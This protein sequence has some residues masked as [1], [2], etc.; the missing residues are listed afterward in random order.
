M[1]C[2]IFSAVF[3]MNAIYPEIKLDGW[4]KV[5]L[6]DDKSKV[7]AHESWN[8]RI[9]PKMHESDRKSNRYY[10]WSSHLVFEE[11][12]Y[13][14]YFDSKFPI[15]VDLNIIVGEC[16]KRL[17]SEDK[18]AL[19]FKHPFRTC[20]YEELVAIHQRRMDTPQNI[21]FIKEMLLSDNFPPKYG[22]TENNIFIRY[23]KNIEFNKMF[24][25]MYT[26]IHNHI[27][28]DQV[29]FMYLLYKT[30]LMQHLIVES[31]ACKRTK[32]SK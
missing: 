14:M 13:V 11:Y 20:I 6:T 7:K 18:M 12:D 28:R 22:L 21:Q 8:I 2:V 31:H 24:D 4:D 3:G 25:Q 5:I 19:F 10:K 16:M 29:V 32:F 30:N 23:N 9:V 15:N 26:L 1:K 27:C 17:T